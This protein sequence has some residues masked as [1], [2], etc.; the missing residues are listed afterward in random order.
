MPPLSTPSSKL[1]FRQRA[2]VSLLPGLIFLGVG[3]CGARGYYFFTNH[4]DVRYLVAPWGGVKIPVIYP[5]EPK[6]S[7]YTALDPC[8]GR[9]ISFTVHEFGRGPSPSVDKANG[10]LRLIAMGG[11]STFGV[12]NPDDAT[13][14]AYL[15]R[16]LRGRYRMGVEVIN[17]GKVGYQI[18]DFL[19]ALSSHWIAYRPDL[20]LYYEGWNDTTL[21][22]V[23]SQVHHDVRRFN[24]YSRIGRAASWAY[25]RSMLYT[26]LV[27]KTRF[28]LVSREK[29]KIVPPIG[30]FR[31]QLEELVQLL[32]R[33][34]IT[35]VFVL[36]VYDVPADPSLRHL[37]LEDEEQVR[38][39]ILR[40]VQDNARP[41]T[42]PLT[43][44]RV[45]QAQV[46][47]EVVRRTGEKFG[48]QVV[49]PWPVFTR[50]RGT[51]PLFCDIVHL[52]DEAN[53][54]LARTIDR[55]LR[56]PTGRR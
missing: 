27:E 8:S 43:K 34:G 51:A 15:E 12:N 25:G 45:V 31:R 41:S 19:H 24:R 40:R 20:V 23:A 35:P 1:T 18:P 17:A 50:Y 32:R 5:V 10:N 37:S 36:Q 16:I 52:T 9:R 3:E 33:H 26:Y 28:I 46:M 4:G 54:L 22:V 49:D 56:L 30:R 39:F 47:G 21:P 38:A 44:I 6:P 48:V 55:E 42:D 2:A 53:Y 14:P 11:S 7:A 29:G 13:W